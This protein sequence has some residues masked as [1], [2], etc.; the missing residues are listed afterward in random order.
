MLIHRSWCWQMN[1]QNI[2]TRHKIMIQDN[3]AEESWWFTPSVVLF[4]D[5][6][7]HNHTVFLSKHTKSS[8]LPNWAS[9]SCETGLYK[10]RNEQFYVKHNS[11]YR[12][13]SVKLSVPPTGLTRETASTHACS[14]P[15]S[16]VGIA[17][18]GWTV[19]E[20]NPGGSEI[21]HPSRPAL[22]PTQPPVQWVPGLFQG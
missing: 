10:F 11:F 1:P 6:T 22:G 14:G 13:R 21:F 15:G 20:S 19:L 4:A 8:T 9:C 17:T 2:W 5:S 12:H 16:S 7:Q 3:R 18:M